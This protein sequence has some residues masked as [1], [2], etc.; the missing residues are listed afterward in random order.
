MRDGDSFVRKSSLSGDSILM[1][2]TLAATHMEFCIPLEPVGTLLQL[3][4]GFWMRKIGFHDSHI[5]SFTRLERRFISGNDRIRLPNGKIGTAGIFR[6]ELKN[7]SEFAGYGWIKVGF[8]SACQPICLMMFPTQGDDEA[9]A[10][11]LSIAAKEVLALQRGA[12]ARLEHRLFTDDWALTSSQFM[13]NL[14][15]HSYDSRV[16]TRTADEGFDFKFK[17]PLFDITASA[18]MV[19]DVNPTSS[20]KGEV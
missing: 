14:P 11:E 6:L 2:K 1:T 13:R 5:G 8:D 19:P 9:N 18:K 17:A 7:G 12:A 20:L 4:P 10:E 15:P 16:G 3:Y